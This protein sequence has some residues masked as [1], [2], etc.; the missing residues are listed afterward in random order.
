MSA[1]SCTLAAVSPQEVT[2][3]RRQRVPPLAPE[4]RRAA[5]IAATLPLLAQHG[6]HVTTRQI[7][8]AAGIAEGTIF[9]A[10]PDKP[11]LILAA[12]VASFDPAPA[13]VGLGEI[14]KTLPLRERILAA[15]RVLSQHV[16]ANMP[17]LAAARA[18]ALEAY[19]AREKRRGVTAKTRA[20]SDEGM[21]GER[22][23]RGE[24]LHDA[25]RRARRLIQRALAALI[26]P[27]SDRL[28]CDPEVAARLLF[29]T[30]LATAGPFAPQ[31]EP[32]RPDEIVPLLLEGLLLPD[33]GAPGQTTI[34]L[35]LS[36]DS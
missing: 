12:V 32:F 28:R 18:A 34:P 1:H 23:P 22:C 30:I 2:P 13:V 6:P 15:A 4:D 19:A 10:F 20:G 35:R 8:E 3:N 26:A 21:P 36:S 27:D 7:A 25:V 16:T 33:G 31:D 9:R 14:D 5:I 11:S 29:S 24:N 17:L